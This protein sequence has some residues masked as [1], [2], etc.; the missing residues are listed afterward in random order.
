MKNFLSVKIIILNVLR[1]IIT[2]LFIAHT[3]FAD[4]IRANNKLDRVLIGTHYFSNGW[5]VNFWSTDIKGRLK[6]DLEQI[7]SLSINTIIVVVPFVGVIDPATK[8]INRVFLEGLSEISREASRLDL[9]VMWRLGY[10]WNAHFGDGHAAN[11]AVL[12]T[13]TGQQR[14][15]IYCQ[16]LGK[17]AQALGVSL[18]FVSWEDFWFV[19]TFTEGNLRLR[20]E[21]A[22]LLGYDKYL[23]EKNKSSRRWEEKSLAVP[24]RYERSYAEYYEFWNYI[25]I[26]RVY[27]V[28]RRHVSNLSAEI[29]VDAVAIY[30]GSPE[31]RIFWYKNKEHWRGIRSSHLLVYFNPYMGSENNGKP[32]SPEFAAKSLENVVREVKSIVGN[33]NIFIDQMIFRDTTP[34]FE[35]AGRLVDSDIP[36]FMEKTVDFLKRETV[37]FSLWSLFDYRHNAVQNPYFSHGLQGWELK[38]G[39]LNWVGE[40]QNLTLQEG[41][42]LIQ[43]L[44]TRYFS[45]FRGSTANICV[46]AN[47]YKG[48]T[49]I[50]DGIDLPVTVRRINTRYE[51]C[52]RA[53]VV[54]RAILEVNATKSITINAVSVFAV[55]Q[56]TGFF[57][58][59]GQPGLLV[60]PLRKLIK[61]LSESKSKPENVVPLFSDK[62]MAGYFSRRL[63]IK[64]EDKLLRITTFA[65]ENWPIE[66]MLRVRIGD[67]NTTVKCRRGYSEYFIKLPSSH[68]EHLIE[69]FSDVTISP[70]RLGLSNDVRDL[71]CIVDKLVTHR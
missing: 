27:E 45:E 14:W 43:K 46:G 29:R 10:M 54:N 56:S 47:D 67:V 5:P 59:D 21:Y 4:E 36:R 66:P 28:A 38:L 12:T 7:A 25:F 49:L 26:D 1:C 64:R 19:D 13:A 41:G 63:N 2:S 32:V 62:W 17:L 8:Q 35:R 18:V 68:G 70:G 40:S 9:T 53:R 52:G 65:P 11:K 60:T 31:K 24:N 22:R 44:D 34:G 55:V 37:G 58:V 48:V 39:K 20:K 16:E 69:V 71:S 33:K 6:E 42:R 50:L 30:D 51:H 15:Q 61:Q 23:Q 57:T 3:S